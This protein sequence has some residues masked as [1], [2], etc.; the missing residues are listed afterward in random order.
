MS[1]ALLAAAAAP[2]STVRTARRVR[3][4]AEA[5][6]GVAAVVVVASLAIVAI[7]HLH[8][9][10][11]LNFVSA[12]FAGLSA[13]LNDGTLYPPLFDGEH[14]GGTRY[15]PLSFVP[16]AALARLTGELIFSGKA[17]SLA[18][19]AILSL[20]LFWIV[21]GFGCGRGA[22]LALASLPFLTNAGVLAA[23]TIRGDLFPVVLQ[24]AAL[25][26]ARVGAS[27][28]RLA[29]AGL[30]CTLAILTKIT[31]VWAPLVI[32]GALLIR[33]RRAAVVFLS[34]WLGTLAAA[35]GGLHFATAGRML[36]NFRAVSV[37]G[38]Q[39]ASALRAP[40]AMFARLGQGGGAEALLIPLATVS[41]AP[42]FLWKRVTLYHAAFLA[43][44]PITLAIF[45]DVGADYNHL[46]DLLVLSVPVAG[47]LWATAAIAGRSADGLRAGL[48]AA[49]CW[50]L[51][52]GWTGHLGRP[53][54]DI[55]TKRDTISSPFPAKPLA[56][57][58]AD[59]AVILSEDPW[60]S[61]ARGRTPTVLD[62]CA[63]ACLT[64]TRGE[65][66]DDL[67]R[68]IARGDFD[69]VVLR[70]HGGDADAREDG[71]WEDRA[72][73]RP[74][75]EAIKAHYRVAAVA[76]GFIVYAPRDRADVAEIRQ[77]AR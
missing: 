38:V 32:A 12:V 73:G 45:T 68:R 34:I 5:A 55:F 35:L 41:C 71:E 17:W 3:V 20:Q 36:D 72:M 60:V 37:G 66:T 50:A 58:V 7:A 39:L 6:A 27:P 74:V 42:A 44:V 21:R 67:V 15:M 46:L 33:D 29:V 23:T 10:Y 28:G 75:I 57:L 26:V 63:L 53:L 19:S 13:R 54:N 48:A 40:V 16:Q 31:A 14:Y 18:L 2:S 30:L 24:L 77:A 25:Q 65:L 70:R 8:D 64:R 76:E 51:F 62:P 56:G 61:L 47:S 22:S 9:R 59:D 52:M 43:S 4:A 1:N 69:R 11:H 49:A